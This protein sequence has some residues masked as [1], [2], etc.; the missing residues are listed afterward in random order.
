MDKNDDGM[1]EM[2]PDMVSVERVVSVEQLEESLRAAGVHD[3]SS[4]PVQPLIVRPETLTGVFEAADRRTFVTCVFK[5]LSRRASKRTS[6]FDAAIFCNETS[7]APEV[8][9]SKWPVVQLILQLDIVGAECY[10][11]V[12]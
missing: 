12:M 4:P 5:I 2:Q 9:P 1:L 11:N 3:S 6:F 8:H 10:D 7:S